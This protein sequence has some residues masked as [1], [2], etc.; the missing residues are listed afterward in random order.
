MLAFDHQQL[1]D[2]GTRA[3]DFYVDALLPLCSTVDVQTFAY[4]SFPQLSH[5][6][7]CC[8]ALAQC[9]RKLDAAQQESASMRLELAKEKQASASCEMALLSCVKWQQS[10]NV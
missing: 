6:F 2:I 1:N 8:Q 7:I 4:F 9:S 5:I 3:H 10:G